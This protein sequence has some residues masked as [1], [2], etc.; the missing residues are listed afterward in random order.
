MP[1]GE[2]I[3]RVG[4]SGWSY[5]TGE[6][7]WTGVVYPPGTKSELGYYATRLFNTV[8]VNVSF[9]RLIPPATARGLKPPAR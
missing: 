8:E 3:V 6:G 4:T 7:K 2:A 5:P 1:T 9:Y